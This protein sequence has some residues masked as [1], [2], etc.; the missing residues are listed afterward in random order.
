MDVGHR[1]MIG[2]GHRRNIQKQKPDNWRLEPLG[3]MGRYLDHVTILQQVVDT[4][5]EGQAF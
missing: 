3:H 1:V 5:N 2:V 4:C